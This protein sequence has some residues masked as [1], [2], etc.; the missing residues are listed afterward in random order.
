MTSSRLPRGSSPVTAG[1]QTGRRLVDTSDPWPGSAI[2]SG[3]LQGVSGA[4]VSARLP[5]ASSTDPA[6]AAAAS[7]TW[8]ASVTELLRARLNA[9]ADLADHPVGGSAGATGSSAAIPTVGPPVYA[10]P[11]TAR[12]RVEPAQDG[13]WFGQLNLQPGNRIVAGLAGRVIQHDQEPLMQAA[14]A[15]LGDL[16]EI[17]AMLRQAQLARFAGD[18]IYRRHVTPLSLGDLLQITRPVHAD[19]TATAGAVVSAQASLASSSTAE[20]AATARFRALTRAAGPGELLAPQG[21]PQDSQ[22]KYDDSWL[23]S[24][25][26]DAAKAMSA[27]AAQAAI[28]TPDALPEQLVQIGTVLREQGTFTDQMT[29]PL[30]NPSAPIAN[31]GFGLAEW[32]VKRNYDYVTALVPA[33]P[34]RQPDV[35]QAL[36][37]PLG[38]L[39]KVT[40]DPALAASARTEMFSLTDAL[41]LTPSNDRFADVARQK[42][43]AQIMVQAIAAGEIDLSD[44]L[45]Q[46]GMAA[47]AKVALSDSVL[48]TAAA[49][50]N[51]HVLATAVQEQPD[52]ALL[53][54]AAV[55][56]VAD[57][58]LGQVTIPT[59]VPTGTDGTIPASRAG[60]GDLAKPEADVAIGEEAA[61]F[62]PVQQLGSL[63][64]GTDQLQLIASGDAGDDL[65][66]KVAV[67]T[68]IIGDAGLADIVRANL[69]DDD[70][71]ELVPDIFPED[72]A[73]RLADGCFDDPE[74]FGD[75][76]IAAAILAL[77]ARKRLGADDVNDLCGVDD[78]AFLNDY[79]RVH[80]TLPPILVSDEE[81]DRIRALFERLVAM[82]WPGT[83]VRD[84]F[85][86]DHSHL[87]AQLAP[88]TTVTS[89][90]GERLGQL[91]AWIPGTWFADGSVRPVLAPLTFD[92]PMYE[93]LLDFDPDWLVPGL[94]AGTQRDLIT[95]LESNPRFV[96]AFLAG[97]SH[98]MS[99]E[100]LW[101]GYPTDLR[102][103]YFRR[104]WSSDSDE[105]TASLHDLDDGPLGTHLDERFDQFLV[106]LVRGEL[107]RRY[108]DLLALALRPDRMAGDGRPV[109]GAASAAA[110]IMFQRHCPPDLLLVGFEL[111]AGQV[112]AA[113]SEGHGPPW[114][115][116][117]AE[118]PSAPRFGLDV[119]VDVGSG[120]PASA[121]SLAWPQFPLSF[122]NFLDGTKG[123]ANIGWN[124]SAADVARLL[125][126]DPFRAVFDL[127]R[128]IGS[129]QPS[130][131]TP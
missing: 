14:W 70:L 77:L 50:V 9:A 58:G 18:S 73:T 45:D 89:R 93:A 86:V 131:Q 91:P 34:A 96:E 112:A 55:E 39:L 106:L 63:E 25:T 41:K 120:S 26:P 81:R 33:T 85:A 124:Q 29:T 99:R 44:N 15:Q 123:P 38:A 27:S 42:L 61:N 66:A 116:V 108:P 13:S 97:L 82:T 92:R 57:A 79:L 22:R 118:H 102:G 68:T 71:A 83:P 75:D 1:W 119:D 16:A 84:P 7:G 54:A 109:F 5:S 23:M 80:Q 30:A 67:D 60:L 19:L 74:S 64:L 111:S 105:L 48:A 126:Q 52:F 78:I 3:R 72:D 69:P 114:W 87:L 113:A 36:L 59:G 107:V 90:V 94:P 130:G 125:L 17:N 56:L 51:P 40:G 11:Q 117:L 49:Q 32:V 31:P 115:L 21:T 76:R 37:A 47:V 46:A 88:S 101:R 53:T 24:M 129:A 6:E 8:P 95:V 12:R 35:A 128:L 28:D 98:E 2:D 10:G 103:T 43:S 122:G 110:T 65:L 127:Q 20:G 62:D 4:L 104:F 121:D 100:L